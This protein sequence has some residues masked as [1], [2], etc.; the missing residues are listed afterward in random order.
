[1]AEVR[2]FCRSKTFWDS[3][4]PADPDETANNADEALPNEAP[5]TASE[6]EEAAMAVPRCR[7]RRQPALPSASEIDPIE[8]KRQE[9]LGIN[10]RAQAIAYVI[11]GMETG[12][13]EEEREAGTFVMKMDPGIESL[14]KKCKSEP[15]PSSS[16]NP[17][18]SSTKI[19]PKPP[20][21]PP[22]THLM[23]KEVPAPSTPPELLELLS[24]RSHAIGVRPPPAIGERSHTIGV[25][26]PS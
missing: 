14:R 20:P 19:K 4:K 18:S 25:R 2:K 21:G 26:P 11:N 7:P 22:P 17:A 10:M 8:E 5:P 24:K 16:S 15:K 13:S 23:K 6:I 1:M 3:P 9:M 12:S